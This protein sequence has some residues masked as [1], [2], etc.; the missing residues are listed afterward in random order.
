MESVSNNTPDQQ[1][2]E[3]EDDIED[4][5]IS[6]TEYETSVSENNVQSE[7]ENTVSESDANAEEL[8]VADGSYYYLQGTLQD[9]GNC[10]VSDIMIYPTGIN[11]FVFIRQGEEGEFTESIVI[12]KDAIDGVV[13]VQFSDGSRITEPLE[14]IYSRDTQNPFIDEVTSQKQTVIENVILLTTPE[15]YVYAQDKKEMSEDGNR[16]SGSGV[17]TV[18]CKYD[19]EERNYELEDGMAVVSLPEFFYGDVEIWCKD[20]AGNYSQ[21]YTATYL[22]DVTKP[23][24]NISTSAMNENLAHDEILVEIMDAGVFA[25]GIQSVC[26]TLNEVESEPELIVSPKEVT[27]NE[28]GQEIESATVY[29]F[30]LQIIEDNSNLSLRV[31]DY[32][33]NVGECSY[34]IT[35][36]AEPE[37]YQ[38][39]IPNRLDLL[40]DPFQLLGEE[41][42]I[43]EGNIVKNLND[44]PVKI[45]ITQFE[46]I[47][48]RERFPDIT[49]PCK[50]EMN[51]EGSESV[52][53][54]EGITE[55]VAEFILQPQEYKD[56]CFCGSIAG[57]TENL[58]CAG[59][60]RIKFVCEF[61]KVRN[62]LVSK[63]E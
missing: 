59:D 56:I 9:G 57:G 10:F 42:I 25:T 24:V 2:K 35:K 30:V 53:L 1:E 46:Y 48:N 5:I 14:L 7:P 43:S 45:R 32:A 60:I 58:W 55:K 39:E 38:M 44:F 19:G 6:E 49:S 40:I 8:I 61:E 33:G 16:L 31:T 23:Q 52:V 29:S 18:Y 36:E 27:L 50:L 54:T 41:Q 4:E 62:L 17:K 12:N 21:M 28:G 11:G 3:Q 26:C 13:M 47:V 20:F 63:K 51:I 22:T 15:L 37:I 34:T